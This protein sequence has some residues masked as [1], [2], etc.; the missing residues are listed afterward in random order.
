M[1]SVDDAKD[2]QEHAYCITEYI[3]TAFSHASNVLKVM[4]IKTLH[5]KI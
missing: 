4:D 1:L 5:Q 2:M 3:L